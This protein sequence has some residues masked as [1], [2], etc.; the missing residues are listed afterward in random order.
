M[1]T[2][3]KL[4]IAA[5]CCAVAGH[6]SVMYGM[7]EKANDDSFFATSS[8]PTV[9]PP[10]H[11]NHS[12]DQRPRPISPSSSSSSIRHR[13]P[14]NKEL[15]NAVYFGT[16]DE[17]Q[18]LIHNGANVNVQM[19]DFTALMA[20]IQRNEMPILTVLLE[21]GADVNLKGNHGITALLYAAAIHSQDNNM[22]PI[23]KVLIKKGAHMNAKE[24]FD[25]TVLMFAA[26]NDRTADIVRALL[27]ASTDVKT[28]V[29]VQDRYGQTALMCAAENKNLPVAQ[30][31]LDA[32]AD[33]TVKRRF[34][35][36]TA[37]DIARRC[38][39]TDIANLI[40][41]YKLTSGYKSKKISNS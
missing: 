17:V 33:A 20:A 31:L 22:I 32:G 27:N 41:S 11:S 35:G 37:A 1:T 13:Q 7:N 8:Q 10:V 19:H 18:K 34:G 30:I 39:S 5:V 23:I 38:G 26:E 40:R 21:A 29:N 24:D 9:L 25:K 36:E 4:L 15:F 16:A 6:C 3:E 12:M 14:S 2:S 28:D